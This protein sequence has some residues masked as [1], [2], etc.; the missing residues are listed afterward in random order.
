[1]TTLSDD[2]AGFHLGRYA[3]G[4]LHWTGSVS[5]HS[6]VTGGVRHN[7]RLGLAILFVPLFFQLL[8]GEQARAP[9]ASRGLER[10][11]NGSFERR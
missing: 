4:G 8:T 10:A 2:L 6:I 9:K 7:R 1:M 11:N 5:R 3:V